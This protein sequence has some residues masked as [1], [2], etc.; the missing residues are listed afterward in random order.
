MKDR[1]DKGEFEVQYCPTG[2]MLADFY[3]KP[4][5]GSLFIKFR[6]VIMGD[7]PIS[8]LRQVIEYKKKERV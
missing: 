1:I 3:T 7:K 6:D 8:S 4:L 5:Q 2:L